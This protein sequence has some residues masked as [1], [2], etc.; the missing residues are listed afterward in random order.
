MDHS[1]MVDLKVLAVFVKVAERRSFAHAARDLGITQSG[2]SNAISRLENQLGVRLLARTTRRVNLTEDGAAF[3][4]RCKRI[5]ADLEEAEMLLGQGRVTP[6]GRLRIDL[7]E[8]FGRLKVVPALRAFREKFPQLALVLTFS[9]RFVDLVE[10]GVDVALRIG[11]LQDSSLIARRVTETRFKVFGAPSYFARYGRPH[12]PEDLTHH[13]CLAYTSSET[14]LI[15]EWRFRYGESAV[16]VT[17]RGDLSLNNSA[18]LCEAACAGYGLVQMHDYYA[19]TLVADGRL[20]PALEAFEPAAEPI[21][22]VYLPAR[23]LAPKVRVFADFM[24]AQ[25]R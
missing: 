14:R 5:L 19:N 2:V 12:S 23:H 21:S 9:N 1:F 7:P 8:S 15:R 18:A 6:R 16:S 4:E 25:F 22:L 17:P 11:A 24:V 3:F 13:N 10:D 20:E